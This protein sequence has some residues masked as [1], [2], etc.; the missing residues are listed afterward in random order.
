MDSPTATQWAARWR[1]DPWV[2][3]G[4]LRQDGDL[5][6]NA[7]AGKVRL[8]WT[9]LEDLSDTENFVV[10]AQTF[11]GKLASRKS[12]PERAGIV[13]SLVVGHPSDLMSSTSNALRAW[14]M[15][16]AW[17]QDTWGEAGVRHA[18][19]AIPALFHADPAYQVVLSEVL[20]DLAR[21]H[22][23]ALEGRDW[24]WH[25][26][27]LGEEWGERAEPTLALLARAGVDVDAPNETGVTAL[28]VISQKLDR[29]EQGAA[30]K[31]R[32]GWLD[33]NRGEYLRQTL[34]ALVTWGADWTKLTAPGD[35]VARRH[36]E[37]HPRVRA[38][39]LRRLA[40]RAKGDEDGEIGERRM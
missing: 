13:A 39:A 18:A 5:L 31:D 14:R 4:D 33:K 29:Q 12:P 10:R 26:V 28:Q 20:A 21:A 27:G 24:I 23:A 36:L 7:S 40:G 34:N 6:E 19:Q 30:R 3:L 35:A 17:A 1:A 38:E 37:G 25:W 2:I 32:G 15:G 22:P 11:L 9:V 16:L 8:L